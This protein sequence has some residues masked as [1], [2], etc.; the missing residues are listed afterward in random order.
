MFKWTF[1]LV[2]SPLMFILLLLLLLHVD[3]L[4][5]TVLGITFVA[6]RLK[7]QSGPCCN[8]AVRKSDKHT[9]TSS[10]FANTKV[11]LQLHSLAVV[12]KKEV[13]YKMSWGD[14]ER[15]T[16]RDRESRRR[17]WII[18]FPVLCCC[19]NTCLFAGFV[20]TASLWVWDPFLELTPK[21][22]Q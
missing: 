18:N 11:Y 9:K 5:A 2:R 20:F 8:L 21:W 16:D 13:A 22:G 17:P 1:V 7:C 19:S 6:L 15:E 10:W 12:E 4:T 3:A 14:R